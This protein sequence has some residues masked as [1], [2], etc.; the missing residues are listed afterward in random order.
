MYELNR[1]AQIIIKNTKPN[2][3]DEV[4]Y[5]SITEI[6]NETK[7]LK[8]EV[9]D[10]RDRSDKNIEPYD[11]IVS[12]ENKDLLIKYKCYSIGHDGKYYQVFKGG[13]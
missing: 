5:G 9:V 13:Q 6:N 1:L 2:M 10:W 12:M 8:L 3:D 7:Q 4:Y 11:L